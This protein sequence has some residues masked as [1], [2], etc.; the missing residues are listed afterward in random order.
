[1][2]IPLSH[3]NDYEYFRIYGDMRHKV[4]KHIMN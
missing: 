3:K 2:N 1:M 4:F